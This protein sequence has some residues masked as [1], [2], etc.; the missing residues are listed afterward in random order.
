MADEHWLGNPLITAA[1]GPH[2]VYLLIDPNGDE[3][4]YVGKGTGWRFAAHLVEEHDIGDEGPDEELGAKRRRIDTIRARGDQPRV[5]FARR[6]IETAVEAYLVEAALIDVVRRPVPSHTRKRSAR[7]RGRSRVN[8]PRRVAGA[9]G[10]A[11]VDNGDAGD[12]HQAV[13][14][15]G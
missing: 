4:F 5:E 12:P 8:H 9:D 11:R 10:Y 2:Y 14:V 1:L 3:V 7:A 15:G 13:V 6:P